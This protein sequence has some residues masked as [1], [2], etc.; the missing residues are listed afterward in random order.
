MSQDVF[1][2]LAMAVLGAYAIPWTRR[3]APMLSELPLKTSI[4]TTL[5]AA[6]VAAAV[7]GSTPDPLWRIV[8]TVASVA[9]ILAPLTLPALARAGAWRIADAVVAIAY[10]TE[11]GV[12]AARRLLVQ[13]ALQQGEAE[14]ALARLPRREPEAFAAQAYA[15]REDWAAV[16]ALDIGDDAAPSAQLAQIEA[17]LAV[18][19]FDEARIRVDALQ[20][21]AEGGRPDPV[22]YRAWILGRARLDAE[23]GDVRHVQE[24]V[25]SAP[26]GAAPDVLLGILARSAEV[27]G[28]VGTAKRLRS[29][30]ARLAPPGRRGPHVRAL[31]AWGEAAP[32]PLRPARGRIPATVGLVAVIALAFVGQLVLDRVLGTFVL[33]G[34]RVEASSL[35]AAFALGFP[36][37]PNAGAWWRFLSYAFVHGNLVHVGF[38]LWV[39]FDIG[40]LVE[41]RRGPGYLIVAFVVGTAMGAYLTA[42]AQAGSAVLLVGASGG[43][44]GVAGALLADASR[45]R[46]AGDRVL[47]RSLLQWMALIVLL[48]VAIPN[49]SLWGHVGGVVGG[50]LWGF[51]RQGVPVGRR[52]DA[53]AGVAA[54]AVLLV[55]LWNVGRVVT[56]LAQM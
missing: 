52:F 27:A 32:T 24:A 51:V 15:L 20:A 35:A 55:V 46:T 45:R 56:V 54:G 28:D 4:A 48:S 10:W 6:V 47:L 7:L 37:F 19:R 33:A 18:G 38:N 43:V 21:R 26:A 29:E 42:V 17:L 44:L 31:D 30:A 25:R 16:L 36:G 11:A 8:A 34:S 2:L 14:A 49:V 1:F 22:A 41:V 13:A 12:D 23:R 40:R 9:W 39:L 50:L 53:I 5:A 3:L